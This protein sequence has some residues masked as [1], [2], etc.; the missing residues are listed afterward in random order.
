MSTL[1]LL[2]LI[3]AERT[4][5]SEHHHAY[6]HPHH[7]PPA[8]LVAS[9]LSLPPC[10]HHGVWSPHTHPAPC[11]TT[12]MLAL[13]AEQPPKPSPDQDSGYQ[14]IPL[15]NECKAFPSG[16]ASG[17]LAFPHHLLPCMNVHVTNRKFEWHMFMEVSSITKQNINNNK[18]NVNHPQTRP[19][20]LPK[21]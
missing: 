14:E 10:S 13:M 12:V 16:S 21:V 17:S 11:L 6:P 8:E 5:L 18:P 19:N 9:S 20:I 15:R 7:M 1:A 4:A 2:W 3:T